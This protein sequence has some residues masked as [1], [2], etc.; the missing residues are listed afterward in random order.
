M[1]GEERNVD[2]CMTK[3]KVV[4]GLMEE[5]RGDIRVYILCQDMLSEKSLKIK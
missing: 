1:Y 3:S 2:E 4:I 5:K